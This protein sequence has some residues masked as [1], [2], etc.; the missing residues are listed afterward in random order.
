MR[1][2]KA[3]WDHF[4]DAGITAARVPGTHEEIFFRPNLPILADT[5]RLWTDQL[6]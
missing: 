5:I 6:P 2:A 4:A 1:V 3:G